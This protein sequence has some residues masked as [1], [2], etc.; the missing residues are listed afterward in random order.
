MLS[1][2]EIKELIDLVAEKKLSGVEIERSGFRLRIEGY[3]GESNGGTSVYYPA[4]AEPMRV[5]AG[6]PAALAAASA[7]AVP[8]GG[9]QAVAEED[10]LHYIVSP[11]VGTFYRAAS[12]ESDPF[13]SPGDR[14]EKNKILCI[15]E[16]MKLMNEIE[17][18]VAGEVVKVF[19]QNGQPVE[20]GEKLFAIK[21]S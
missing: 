8:G 15:I 12:P 17:S 13:V 9:E 18:D 16:A 19:P 6:A 20:Y 2:K 3:R 4:L 7:E 11:I 21:T 1:F 5:A 14:V 10:T